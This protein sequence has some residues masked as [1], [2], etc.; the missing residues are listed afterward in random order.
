[1]LFTEDFSMRHY[2]GFSQIGSH[3]NVIILLEYIDLLTMCVNT[4]LGTLLLDNTMIKPLLNSK[5]N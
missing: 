4:I 1:M 5:L 3:L 2:V